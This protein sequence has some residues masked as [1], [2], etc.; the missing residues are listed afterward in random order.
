[1]DKLSARVKFAYGMGQLAERLK[2][3]GFETFLFFY[4]TQVQG[5]SGT[6]AGTAILIALIFDAVSDPLVGSISDNWK[7]RHG[8]RHPFMLA[9]AIPMGIFF[10]VL[11]NP[12]SS[13]GQTGLFA[14]LTLGSIAVRTAMTVYHVPYM[15][16]GAELSDDYYE[17]TSIV[18]WRTLISFTL[19][20]AFILI[21][22]IAFFPESAEFENG[23][24]NPEGYPRY[25]VF[26]ALLMIAA[27]FCTAFF[28]PVPS[29]K[30]I[31]S[32]K[33]PTPLS[34]RRLALELSA[35]WGNQS[36]RS[37][38]LGFT[39]YGALLGL[40]LTL[41]THMNVYFWGFN[42]E[43]IP[44][45]LAA[46]IVG[47]A[48]GPPLAGPLHK[49]FDKMPTLLAGC[50]VATITGNLPII[51]KLLGLLPANGS[52]E[53]L[54][55]I[56]FFLLLTMTLSAANIVSV[57]SMMAD[58]AEEH[59]LSAGESKQGIIFSALSFSGK[60][61]SG[62]GHFFAGVGLDLIAFPLHLEPSEVTAESVNRLGLLNVFT[63]TLVAL[64]LWAFRSY[65]ITRQSQRD[66]QQALADAQLTPSD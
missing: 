38:F 32:A 15:A 45:L 16:L 26:A 36:F 48:L 47:F 37:L 3:Q 35:A 5:L 13:F 17:R 41:T 62:F 50:V 24:L 25:A 66:T 33:A 4:F 19:S 23:M 51:L 53:L 54:L 7:G 14:W 8:R 2:N 65:T 44:W 6:L 42:T 64:A 31:A 56:A 29:D 10:I 22:Y 40:L 11:F 57:G 18:T 27:I 43:Q 63:I 60:L 9:A 58:V 61:S 12:P 52:T 28:T 59:S 30:N 34:V 46:V 20:S 21:S 39:A 49:R 55:V 1:M